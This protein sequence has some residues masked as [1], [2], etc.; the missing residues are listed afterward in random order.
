MPDTAHPW[1]GKLRCPWHTKTSS[2]LFVTDF[3]NRLTYIND[4]AYRY[5]S[6]LKGHSFR[7]LIFSCKL[8]WK[9]VRIS[10]FHVQNIYLWAHPL[11]HKD[12]CG[13]LPHQQFDIPR[14]LG[15]GYS[16]HGAE[17][18]HAKKFSKHLPRFTACAKKYNTWVGVIFPTEFL[19]IGCCFAI[20]G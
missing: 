11:L 10:E 18:Q 9:K 13:K 12:L 8:I 19:G 3:T 6:V 20:V 5:R 17:A 4:L 7:V 1:L 15:R 14:V 16:E 2:D